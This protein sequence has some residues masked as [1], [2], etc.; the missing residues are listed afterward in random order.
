[1]KALKLLLSLRTSQEEQTTLCMVCEQ[2]I[3][4]RNP[5]GSFP[6]ACEDLCTDILFATMAQ[7][8][9]DHKAKK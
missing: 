4:E 2:E 3:K 7:D 8:E 6:A 9:L 5:D 1:M